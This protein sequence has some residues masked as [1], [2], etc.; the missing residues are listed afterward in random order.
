M[1]VQKYTTQR[2]VTLEWDPLI[3]G[4]SAKFSYKFLSQPF[5]FSLDS[6]GFLIEN[7]LRDVASLENFKDLLMERAKAMIPSS[8]S[9][10]MNGLKEAV[11]N[12]EVKIAGL[13]AELR[14]LVQIGP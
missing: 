9:A 6:R 12:L 3:E 13:V 8:N 1:S 11:E 4:V 5:S 2:S 10:G 14:S 7:Y